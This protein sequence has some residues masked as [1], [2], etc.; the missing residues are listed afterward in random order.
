MSKQSEISQAKQLASMQAQQSQQA[1]N[2]VKQMQKKQ[3]EKQMYEEQRR[4]ILKKILSDEARQR[5]SNIALVKPAN[6]EAIQNQIMQQYSSG[7]ING[8]VT[9]Q[10][11]KVLLEQLNKNSNKKKTKITFARK[12]DD[13]D[14]DLDNL[15]SDDD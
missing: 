7:Q 4:V 6:A 14:D 13:D 11:V 1:Q 9:E 15:W 8:K 5:L 10:Q 3:E 2:Q 12:L